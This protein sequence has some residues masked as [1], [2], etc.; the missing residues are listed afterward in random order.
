MIIQ[1]DQDE[2]VDPRDAELL[3]Q[4]ANNPKVLWRVENAGHV[5]AFDLDSNAYLDKVDRFF[6]DAVVEQV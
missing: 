5:E 3:Y 6:R 1:G 2:I 4:A